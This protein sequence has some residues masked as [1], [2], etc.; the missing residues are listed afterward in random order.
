MLL[1]HKVADT[2]L[3]HE[4]GIAYLEILP[5]QNQLL[6]SALALLDH[7]KGRYEMHLITNGFETTQRLKLQYSGIARYF[8][9]MITSEKSHS[10]KPHKE[11]FDYALNL[12]NADAENSL[13][14]GDAL[15]IDVM[16]AIHAGWDAIYFNPHKKPHDRKPTYEV[17]HLQ[18]VLAIL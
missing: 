3:A 7:C 14:I 1:D 17:S 8:T 12:A 16:G 13:M 2:A 5:T 15:E 11:I 6:P 10:L 9:H 4:L 18:E